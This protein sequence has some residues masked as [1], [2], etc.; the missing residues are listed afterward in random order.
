M[1]TLMPRGECVALVLDDLAD[2][3]YSGLGSLLLHPERVEQTR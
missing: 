2:L 1:E 3:L